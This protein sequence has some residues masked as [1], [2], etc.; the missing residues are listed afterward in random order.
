MRG[1]RAQLKSL[2]ERL[3]KSEE[4]T[5]LADRAKSLCEAIL[6]IEKQI[7]LPDL[8]EGWPGRVNQG[9][10]PLRRLSALP[11]VVGLG[12]YPPTDQSFAVHEK[13]SG[14]IQLQLDA[15]NALA[16]DDLRAFNE[17]L[18]FRGIAFVG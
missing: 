8:R 10:D 12:E 11:S 1:A 3:T 16:G 2:A 18:A 7:F 17:E 5:E 9:T 6:G 14:I 4:H 13:L 15:F